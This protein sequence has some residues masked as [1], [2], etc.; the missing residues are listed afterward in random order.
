[1]SDGYV[2]QH[3]M[4]VHDSGIDIPDGHHVHHIYGDKLDNRIDNLDVVP[5]DE[6]HR[7]HIKDVVVNQFGE[8]RRDRSTEEVRRHRAET[9][10]RNAESRSQRSGDAPHGTLGGYTNWSC[11]CVKCK[12]AYSEYRKKRRAAKRRLSSSSLPA[13]VV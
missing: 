10:R 11:R 9:M 1:M 8:W 2:L 7:R 5:A 6:H 3:R 12:L 13:S 4:V